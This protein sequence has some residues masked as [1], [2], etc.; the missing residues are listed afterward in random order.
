MKNSCPR[1]PLLNPR[2][3]QVTLYD[4]RDFTKVIKLSILMG[5]YPGLSGGRHNKLKSV[6][7][8]RHEKSAAE[9]D[10]KMEAKGYNNERKGLQDSRSKK[11]QGNRSLSISEKPLEET[12]FC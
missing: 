9:G 1:C 7:I 4:K 3:V 8:K 5:D 11:K 10:V 12:Q 6:L 2:P